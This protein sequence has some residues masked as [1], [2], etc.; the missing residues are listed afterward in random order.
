VRVVLYTADIGDYDEV[1]PVVEQDTDVEFV[2]CQRADAPLVGQPDRLVGRW[3][4]CHPH[5]LFPDADATIWI[6]ACLEITSPTFASD[7]L[8][9]S[10]HHGLAMFQHPDRTN[11]ADELHA[12]DPMAKYAG[13]LHRKMVAELNATLAANPPGL[14][15]MTTIARHHRP[16]VA[17]VDRLLWAETRRWSAATVALDQLILPFVLAATHTPVAPL[18]AT[19]QG[20]P[21][22][23]L[24]HN[25]WFIRHPHR[26]NT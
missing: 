8:H 26:R 9:Q 21:G 24:W 2:R 4:K 7:L 23:N 14:W 10:A 5:E 22:G 1:W 12:A 16:N 19:W 17:L 11:V 20:Q 3:F 25:D 15:A 18:Q 13:N 6:D